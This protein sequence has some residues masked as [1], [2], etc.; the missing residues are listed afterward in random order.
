[1]KK[2][3]I[4]GV[5]SV[6]MDAILILKGL[7]Y[8]V[9]ACAMAKDGPGADIADHFDQIDFLDIPKVIEHIQRNNIDAV[10]S[11]GSDNAMPVASKISETLGLPL[12]VSSEAAVICNN[13]A[14]MRKTLGENFIGNIPF[15]IMDKNDD[16]PRIPLPFIMKPSDSQGQRGIV[17][18]DDISKYYKNFEMVKNYSR[19]GKVIIEKFVDGPEISVNAYIVDGELKFIV[20]SDRETW[21]QYIGLIHKHIVPANSLN[22]DQFKLLK[23]I[24]EKA[25]IKIGIE[26]GPAYFQVKLENGS[27]Y[28]IEITPRLDGCHMW[29]LL[30]YH[31][32]IN[33]LKLTF[34]HL[35]KNDFS[36]L[37]KGPVFSKG[38]ELNFFCQAPNTV[39]KQ[40]EFSI[41]SN[42]LEHFFYYNSGETIRPINGKYEKIGY[43]IQKKNI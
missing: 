31:T 35:L 36:E 6:Q 8:E 17:L 33:L 3:L 32:G 5:T 12:F 34:D 16:V 29:A 43:V 10:Y 30:T 18:V 1:M 41:P 22:E 28:I 26:N 9:F 4:L 37:D 21:P 2:I 39:I 40:E 25:C 42:A 27:P 20:A 15:Q 14:L 19:T 13:K 7:G 38:Y 24:V 23:D 11:V